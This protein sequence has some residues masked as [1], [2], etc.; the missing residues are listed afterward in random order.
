MN[1]S[2]VLFRR[3]HESRGPDCFMWSHDK[4]IGPRA[5]SRH[6]DI[7]CICFWYLYWCSKDY[8]RKF[9]LTLNW[10]PFLQIQP[11]FKC[12]ILTSVTLY[13]E[14]VIYWHFIIICQALDV[15]YFNVQNHTR[16]AFLWWSTCIILSVT[17]ISP[18]EFSPFLRQPWT[19]LDHYLKQ[20]REQHTSQKTQQVGERSLYI[21]ICT[22]KTLK[23]I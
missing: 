16:Y 9:P 8:K 21:D 7:K 11:A 14:Q 6:S 15:S 3:K 13:L 10:Q 22:S 19:L 4:K 17:C 12:G 18:K 2:I 23:K 1:F 5:A 20:V